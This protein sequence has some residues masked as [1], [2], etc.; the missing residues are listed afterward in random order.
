MIIIGF[1]YQGFRGPHTG[2]VKFVVDNCENVADEALAKIVRQHRLV[3]T[4]RTQRGSADP[5]R[6]HLAFTLKWGL[7]HFNWLV[8]QLA[9]RLATEMLKTNGP[10][11]QLP[12]RLEFT[13]FMRSQKNNR[14]G[15]R[16]PNIDPVDIFH[17]SADGRRW[18]RLETEQ[19]TRRPVSQP[20]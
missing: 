11:S 14:S 8:R 13:N 6:C 10:E 7:P 12:E 1:M 16:G 19:R 4:A 17:A 15:L 5:T 2:R 9:C 20:V 18:L 3:A